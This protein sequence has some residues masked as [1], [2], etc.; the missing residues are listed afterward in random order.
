M[1]T[2]VYI[3]GPYSKGDVA[4]NVK[5]AY[6]MADKIALIGLYPFVPHHTH[7]WH[8][9]FP[10]KYEFWLDQDNAFLDVCNCLIRIPGDSNGADLEVGRAREINIPVFYSFEELKK[11]YNL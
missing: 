3:A 7:F 4:V 9:L 8:M 5:N 6:E 1:K 11:H 10:K 2:R